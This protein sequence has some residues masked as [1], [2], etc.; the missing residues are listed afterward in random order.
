[1]TNYLQ[2]YAITRTGIS[3]VVSLKGATGVTVSLDK[4]GGAYTSQ[5]VFT[6]NSPATPRTDE[7]WMTL[8]PT[9]T[10][11]EVDVAVPDEATA[12]AIRCTAIAGEVRPR[13]GARMTVRLNQLLGLHQ[14][15]YNASG[16]QD[17]F[18]NGAPPP[19]PLLVTGYNYTDDNYELANPNV[20]QT[21]RTLVSLWFKWNNGAVTDQNNFIIHNSG[22]RF[23]F[24][25][26]GF[27]QV[28]V[29]IWDSVPA[30]IQQVTSN[31]HTSWAT[32]D[33]WHH[34]LFAR[35]GATANLYIDDV[36]DKLTHSPTGAGNASNDS[37]IGWFTGMAFNDTFGLDGCISNVYQNHQEYLDITV[38]ANRRKFIDA[39]GL[40]V[41]PGPLGNGPTGSAPEIWLPDGLATANAGSEGNYA[42]VSGGGAV[43]C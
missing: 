11:D 2:T 14:R 21:N 39:A 20:T 15:R 24:D 33:L 4:E 22:G 1:M 10:S 12:V 26:I 23:N 38:E 7:G 29:T 43:P 13:T 32:D 28:Q 5:L 18:D 42:L 3:D 34:L 40:P 6:T 30:I 8:T 27:F 41:D 36:D 31:I 37:A 9:D 17:G 16:R 25:W 19:P 35:N